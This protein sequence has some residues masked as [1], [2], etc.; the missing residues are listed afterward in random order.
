M[1]NSEI[2]VKMAEENITAEG[3][4]LQED[5]QQ[6]VIESECLDVVYPLPD[7]WPRLQEKLF[8]RRNLYFRKPTSPSI[9]NVIH[10]LQQLQDKIEAW[11]REVE[12]EILSQRSSSLNSVV[13]D[14]PS[15]QEGRHGLG[16]KLSAGRKQLRFAADSAQS[17]EDGSIYGS[18]LES[19]PVTEA[20]ISNDLLIQ[21]TGA[22]MPQ[23]LPSVEMLDDEL[24]KLGAEDVI[25]E[26]VTLLGRLESDRQDTES[27]LEK[28]KKRVVWLQGKID[29]LAHKRLVELPKA[30]QKEHEACA[31][32]IA[33]L[34]WHC[35]YRGRQLTR[36]KNKVENGEMLNA[37]L[38]EDIAFVKKHCP[39][40]E[41][42]LDLEMEAMK[43]IDE[44]QDQTIGELNKMVEK[45]TK[46][47]N[48]SHEAHGKADMERTHI[49]KE[50]DSVRD[51]LT[52]INHE[53]DEAKAL[54]TSYSHKCNDLRRKLLNNSQEKVVLENRNEN[55][56]TA[57][58]MEGQ[59]VKQTQDMIVDAEFEHRRLADQN[60]Q[61]NLKIDKMR[62]DI[63]ELKE[64]A[65]R[66]NK[67]RLKEL[68]GR[69]QR[70]NEMSMDIE[71]IQV[72]LKHCKRQK[73][74]D[75]KNMERIIREMKKVETQLE[76]VDEEHR[77]TKVINNSMRGKFNGEKD[78][79]ALKEDQIQMT[80]EGL[81]KQHKEETHARTILQARILADS[82][83]FQ[84]L[85][86]EAKKKRDKVG[87]KSNEIEIVVAG[88]LKEVESQRSMKADRL[89]TISDLETVIG[90]LKVKHVE[91]ENNLKEKKSNLEPK[92]KQLQ[93]AYL[94]KQ[95]KLDYMTART[96]FIQNKLA[97]QSQSENFMDRVIKNT[98]EAIEELSGEL[99]EQT[100]KLET[101]Q[102]QEK[103]LKQNLTEVAARLEKG[104]DQHLEHM[105]AR[106]IVLEE[107]EA[108]LKECLQQNGCHAGKYRLLQQEFYH[109][110]T[111]LL[112]EFEIRIGL[113]A[114]LKDHKQL[115]CLQVRLHD[116]LTRYFTLRGLY[117]ENKLAGFEES[118]QENADRILSL[119]NEMDQAIETI[120]HFLSDQVDGT[121]MKMVTA[122]ADTAL[123][124]DGG[125]APKENGTAPPQAPTQMVWT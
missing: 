71:D 90:D 18:R 88:I 89:K 117:N 3:N 52:T 12:L 101:G 28:E 14:G 99:E 116:A 2:A 85:Q 75:A 122:A 21:G 46:T 22:F 29:T 62:G 19:R 58:K 23:D 86:R 106:R 65:E 57:E 17:S 115:N 26:V 24:P 42:K 87:K 81:H 72:K 96:N 54:H 83:D 120:S 114:S 79:V 80:M 112:K 73:V 111:E 77:N 32:D 8:K 102:R 91:T 31:A 97:E 1:E 48:K 124:R 35:S 70:C 50:L 9:S 121:A 7:G 39:L 76:V 41:E 34:K 64:V 104:D 56:R 37:R 78:K 66:T 105:E 95:K 43:R 13:D 82:T 40:V 110:K 25:D 118:S 20:S 16:S 30:V 49:K 69:E 108:Q 98:S 27:L 45:M 4:H 38:N 47:Q 5:E 63:K 74:A 103:E 59:N 109:Q 11:S 125:D 55:A 119:Q 61:Y 123:Q 53:L 10:H 60:Y 67:E 36:V 94:E 100:I 33:E 92:H 113:E 84:K 107:L 44:A 68:R 51:A 15:Y 6:T 93:T